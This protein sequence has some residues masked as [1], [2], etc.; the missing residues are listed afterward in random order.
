MLKDLWD[1]FSGLEKLIAWELIAKSEN[2]TAIQKLHALVSE[3]LVRTM[4]NFPDEHVRGEEEAKEQQE[5]FNLTNP[6]WI[7]IKHQ[8]RLS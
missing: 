3:D 8:L 6:Y 7:A 4:G 5:L 2:L 1:Q